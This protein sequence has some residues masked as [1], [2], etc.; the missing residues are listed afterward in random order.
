MVVVEGAETVS[1]APGVLDDRAD[2]LGAAVGDT[3]GV[4]V[5]QYLGSPGSQGPS[6]PRVRFR[7]WGGVQGRDGLGGE[8]PAGGRG[9]C[10]NR[11]QRC[12]LRRSLPYLGR[13]CEEVSAV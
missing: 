4:E 10:H 12:R 3:A 6:T 7:G 2:G 9:E 11:I 1:R 5:G 13:R 8:V